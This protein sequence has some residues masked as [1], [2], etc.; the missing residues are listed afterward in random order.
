MK[1]I[2][3]LGSGIMV[4]LPVSIK[5]GSAIQEVYGGSD[6]QTQRKRGDLISL[7]LI[8]KENRLK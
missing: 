1:C 4:Y 7:L 8:F 3:E 5:I 6:A 2:V